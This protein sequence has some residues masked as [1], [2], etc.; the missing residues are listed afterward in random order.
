LKDR[1]DSGFLLSPTH[2]EEIT[3][4]A[5]GIV[6]SYKDLPLRLYQICKL[7]VKPHIEPDL[8]VIQ[9]EN[10]AMNYGHAKVFFGRR[11]SS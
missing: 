11:S 9:L 10:T 3:A 4:L 1:K 8:N 5:A 2:E 7:K 6:R